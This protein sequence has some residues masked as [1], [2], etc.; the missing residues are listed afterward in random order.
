VGRQQITAEEIATWE[1]LPDIAAT[2]AKRGLQTRPEAGTD[3]ELHLQL[4]D[5]ERLVLVEAGPGTPTAEFEP[6]ERNRRATLV[7]RTDFT[8]FT[9]LI[10]LPG[11]AGQRHGRTRYRRLPFTTAE[12][13][14]DA[15]G[16]STAL[17]VLNAI[18]YGS[19]DWF[20]GSRSETDRVV[21]RFYEAVETL[22]D[23]LAGAVVGIPEARADARQRYVQALLD[24]LVFLYFLQEKG[25]LDG[26]PDYLHDRQQELAATG[27]D[28]YDR[29]YEP[30]FFE[31]LGT[32]AERPAFGS[33]PDLGEAP[34]TRRPV[35][36]TFETVRLGGSTERTNEL[37]GEI[38]A[39]L[40]DWAWN[41]DERR[42]VVG[43]KALSPA[44]L[45]HVFERTVNRKEMGAYYT[46]EAIT[47]FMAR[48]SIHP[49][50]LD[51]LV[52]ATG[53]EYET[54]D[55]V[56]GLTGTD[57]PEAGTVSGS[58]TTGQAPVDQVET[59]HVETL[60]HEILTD[61]SVLDPAAGSGA[62][63]LAA[64]EVLLDI[65]VQCLEFFE[66]VADRGGTLSDRTRAEL[67]R[68]ARSPGGPALYAKRRIVRENL[69]G[70]D[71]DDGAVA[72]CK[73]R[74][75]LSIVADMESEPEAVE[76]LPNADR[77]IRQGNA[78]IG[79]TEPPDT[80]L[81]GAVDPPDPDGSGDATGPVADDPY[82]TVLAQQERHRRADTSAEARAAHEA[83]QARID[84]H[85]RTLNEQ[86]L[87]TFRDRADGD[88]PLEALDAFDPFHWPLEFASVYADGGFDV[89]IGNPP[90]DVLKAD[91]DQFFPEYDPEFR[92]RPP[93]EKDATQ[94]ELLSQPEIREDWERFQARMDTQAAYFN[95]S[96]Q[97]TLQDPT[98]D[99]RAV[100]SEN[101]LSLL[102]LE[103]VLALATPDSEVAQLLPGNAFIGASAKDLRQ[104]L[105]EDTSIR[106]HVQFENGGIF[107]DLHRQYKFCL[108]TF[109]NDGTTESLRGCYLQGSTDSLREFDRAAVDVP[110]DV[111]AA[112]SPEAGTFPFIRS[113]EQI[114]LLQRIVQQ[115]SIGDRLDDAW[116]AEP[117]TE[118]H[119]AQD[120]DRF[121]ESERAGDYPVYG[122]GNIY[123][124]THDASIF[125]DIAPPEFWSVDEDADP[126]RSAKRR[127]R[128][129]HSNA[130][131]PRFTPKAAI[132]E[133]FD[134]SGS[135]IGFVNDLLDRHGRGPLSPEDILLDCTEYRLAYR[136]IA[137][138]TNERGLIA[139][140]LPP[141]VVCHH[142]LHTIRPYVI[143]P[144]EADLSETPLHGMYT[145]V[146][147]DREL[148]AAAGLL[149]S[150][151]FDY[152][153]RMKIDTGVVM[154]KFRESQVPRLTAGDDWFAYIWRRAARLNCYGDAFAEMRERLGGVDPVTGM[155]DRR[156]LQAE[157]DAAVCEAYGLTEAEVEFLLEEFYRVDSPRMMDED[158]FELVRQRYRELSPA[159]A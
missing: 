40:S 76:P 9:L 2:L 83:A 99:G 110:R 39:F 86:L 96:P 45:G 94:A 22:R 15:A 80:S 49:A 106:H 62:F 25:L 102:F 32:E 121:L 28:V 17:R 42:E 10:R 130:H 31:L 151:V 134:G 146:F 79:Y 61:L 139:A 101:D 113:Q 5:S 98:V 152:L 54:V 8:A 60:Y 85:S 155:A 109:R 46:P 144:T 1:A 12:V 77:T 58:R 37:F 64:Q 29:L 13:A 105:L 19:T 16:P 104:K 24:R 140:V 56:F 114:S 107:A 90:W 159:D 122:G 36:E 70:V 123:Q 157:I 142:K 27:A 132:Y 50:L 26:N 131:D 68:I 116:F 52:D 47:G 137:N 89:L 156:R 44:V 92:G 153:I 125:D 124:F 95:H 119:R 84:A 82:R 81:V 73:L 87:E 100:A 43:T 7:A 38:L 135:Q 69:Y 6:R 154:Y 51:R 18:E 34:F 120:A 91:R 33:L 150:L 53:R 4:T 126:E 59:R 41:V 30:L 136:E 65:Y 97:Y 3:S 74:L 20:R 141:G 63:L 112:F 128:V 67:D 129:K 78:L 48:R 55:A 23:R 143:E 138:A 118:L 108:L 71:I 111:L 93:A 133:A 117:Y 127:I 149:N 35:E 88:L 14:T 147:T 57:G 21:T 103:R 158:Y 75:W 11:P 72:V 148:F 115:P 145:R 66:R